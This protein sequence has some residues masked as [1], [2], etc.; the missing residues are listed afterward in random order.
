MQYA[1]LYMQSLRLSRGQTPVSTPATGLRTS[2]YRT[3]ET[4]VYEELRQAIVAGRHKPGEPLVASQL[5]QELGVSRNPVTLA[6]KRLQSEGFVQSTPHRVITVSVLAAPQVREIYKMRCALEALAAREATVNATPAQVRELRQLA[7]SLMA[8]A[9]ESDPE[10]ATGRSP[11]DRQF[12][13]LLRES[14]GMP[15]VVATLNNLYDQ[16][17]YYRALLGRTRGQSEQQRSAREHI[18]IV[19]AIEKGDAELAARVITQHVETSAAPLIRHL[20]AIGK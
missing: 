6:L 13:R 2:E 9:E 20:E 19:E 5:A 10:V 1:A 11:K 7:E 18:E 14:S 4:L 17:E 15:L 16:C 8:D 12:H 3:L